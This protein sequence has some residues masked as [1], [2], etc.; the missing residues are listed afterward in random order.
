VREQQF[1]D[2]LRRFR[3]NPMAAGTLMQLHVRVIRALD[4]GES[5]R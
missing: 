1:R 4:T 2:H 3:V 5:G